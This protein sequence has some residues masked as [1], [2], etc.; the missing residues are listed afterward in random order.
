MT[1][2]EVGDVNVIRTSAERRTGAATAGVTM[3]AA[4][5]APAAAET[6]TDLAVTG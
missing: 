5:T 2:Q 4:T 1:S 6:S 3:N